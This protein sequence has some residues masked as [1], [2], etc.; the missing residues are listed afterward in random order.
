MLLAMRQQAPAP[1]KRNFL[2]KMEV[3]AAVATAQ[4]TPLSIEVLTLDG[5]REHEVLIQM[6][7]AGLCHSD[8]SFFNGSRKWDDYP[9]VLGHE[10]AGIV[11]ECGKG[12]TSVKPGDHVIPV[13]IPECG[14][15]AACLSTKTNL[16]EEYFLPNA[17]CT[18][19]RGTRAIPAFCELGT[20]SEH[21]IVREMQVTRIR[22]DAPL[23]VVCC[24]G[25][26]G[27]TGLGAA[28]FTARVESGS[29]V[30]V[31]GLGGIGMNVVEGARL[32]GA[33]T[34]IGIDV[35]P[36]K[37]VAGRVA[38]LTHF[39][40]PTLIAG[41]LVG[42]LKELTQGGADYSFECVG[43]AAILRQAIECTRRGWGTAVM[44]GVPPGDQEITLRGRS[45]LEG[46][47]LMGSYLGN[48]K[49]RSQLPG[50][51]DMY[52]DG[53][54]ALDN[55]ISHRI[56]LDQINEGFELLASGKSLRSVIDF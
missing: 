6:K 9:I 11:V 18:R 3:R 13:G 20:F 7:S 48:V 29:T 5:P 38:G 37:E 21:I 19:M 12:V 25:C 10:G 46:R 40:N 50:L 2:M 17:R 28:L 4:N 31:F 55:L 42:H 30:V 34:I 39:I 51:V 49:T 44:I 33:T 16:C 1:C 52:M 56:S 26:A 54:I 36:G 41:D 24:L 14:V 15:C 8:L 43:S 22:S 45:I 27:A 35:N 47:R 23:D 32:A 53:K